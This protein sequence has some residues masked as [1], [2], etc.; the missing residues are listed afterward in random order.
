[1]DPWWVLCLPNLRLTGWPEVCV[2]KVQ[3]EGKSA[4]HIVGTSPSLFTSN[5]ELSVFVQGHFVLLFNFW[6]YTHVWSWKSSKIIFLVVSRLQEQV[7]PGRLSQS[8][9]GT[10][11]ILETFR[12]KLKNPHLV[13]M[14]LRSEPGTIEMLI[15]FVLNFSYRMSKWASSSHIQV[16]KSLAR[17]V[18]FALSLYGNSD[19]ELAPLIKPK[20]T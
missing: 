1:M 3:S 15:F 8:G 11:C 2:W 12:R 16:R 5:Y 18:S 14:Q 10:V 13:L 19:L 17:L 20:R 9:Q 7:S 4:K 6:W